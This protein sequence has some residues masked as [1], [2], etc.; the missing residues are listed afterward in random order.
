MRG[1]LRRPTAS[2]AGGTPR[3]RPD[4]SRARPSRGS[5]RGPPRPSSRRGTA[6]RASSRRTRPR[7]RRC[8]RRAGCPRREGRA[9]SPG[10]P[11]ARGGRRSRGAPSRRAPAPAR[12][13]A[14][15]ATGARGSR[16]SRPARAA[17]ASSASSV[18]TPIMPMSCSR[19][20]WASCGSS[21]QL[22][23]DDLGQRERELRD[24]RRV[25]GRLAEAPAPV[26]VELERARERLDGRGGGFER[27]V[28]S[29]S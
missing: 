25:G 12:R 18:G 9:G 20:P 29:S 24:A 21:D 1:R 26:V 10:R 27:V 8:A 13:S 4:R 17:P 15:R 16:R 22:G 2:R 23:R 3:P 11:S 7:P 5:R 6:G 28:R 14:R 19:N